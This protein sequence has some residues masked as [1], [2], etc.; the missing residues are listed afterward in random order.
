MT[1]TFSGTIAPAK[2]KLGV[3]CV[4]LGA[5]TTTFM[6]GVENTRRGLGVPVGS[7]TQMAT[8]RL[9]KRTEGRSPLIKDFIP[10]AGLDDL[11]FG[12]W[13]PIADASGILHGVDLVPSALDA[14]RGADAAI[15]VT[16]W[17]EL[18]DLAW[19]DARQ[20][21]RNP[22]VVDGRNMLDPAHMRGLG[23]VY[24]GIGRAASQFAGLPETP[25]PQTKLPH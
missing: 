1:K 8:I 24:E 22:L 13:D 11:V 14:L 23:F 9:G 4:G 25:E 7:L 3:L 19:A 17:P 6:A 12:A 10:L 2:G 21:M 15:V 18:R 16:D 5:V 20:S